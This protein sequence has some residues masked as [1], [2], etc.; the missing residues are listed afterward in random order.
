MRYLR[1]LATTLVVLLGSMA[2]AVPALLTSSA[3]ARPQVERS[4]RPPGLVKKEGRTTSTT[5]VS[6]PTGSADTTTSTTSAGT[7][8]STTSAPSTTSTTARPAT[9]TTLATST[10]T[11]TASGSSATTVAG[12]APVDD[13]GAVI[14]PWRATY[15]PH[16]WI[17]TNKS[18]AYIENAVRSLAAEGFTHQLHNLGFLDATGR[19][20]STEYAGLARWIQVS[21]QVDPSQGIILWVSG[22]ESDHVNRTE[23][24]AEIARWLRATVDAYG[25][26]GI[27]L[28]L[29]PFGRD[30]PRFL[31]LLAAVRQE[32]G[33]T[34]LGVNGPPNGR[35]SGAFLAQLASSVDA[36]SP[37]FYDTT[38]TD[39]AQYTELVRSELARYLAAVGGDAA[40]LPS[41]PAYS[42]NPWHD[43]RVENIA[44]AAAGIGALTGE[45]PGGAAVYWWWEFDETARLQWRQAISG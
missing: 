34:W 21:R 35:W 38:L 11:T 40:V 6:S 10:T 41:L 31:S 5:T 14:G 22:S 17:A 43:P 42:A 29:E 30:N 3:E 1:L 18:S 23:R 7:T 26:D 25:V 27:L 15:L 19:V 12:T 20:P 4:A 32:L 16:G 2:V 39:P 33:D 37:M 13:G 8:T 44:T 36:M 45:R 9:S 24:H 28:D